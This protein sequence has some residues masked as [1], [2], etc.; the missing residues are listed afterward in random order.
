MGAGI[1]K[2][3][4]EQYPGMFMRY[5]I[6]CKQGV[7]TPG[8]VM[9]DDAEGRHIANVAT[10]NHWQDPSQEQWV[11]AGIRTLADHF[12][13]EDVSSAAM[14]MLGCGLGGLDPGDVFTMMLREFHELP[15]QVRV[16]VSPSDSGV[17][18]MRSAY[19]KWMES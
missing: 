14:T 6:L 7:I 11:S 1:A 15:T 9:F 13:S 3:F 16:Y 19:K 10:K 2:Q 5:R 12:R 8:S 17:Q 18:K 4:K